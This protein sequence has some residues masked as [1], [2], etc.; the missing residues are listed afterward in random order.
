MSH[1]SRM[2]RLRIILTGVMLTVYLLVL[3][4]Q[5]HAQTAKSRA[6]M[7]NEQTA[8][9]PY[10]DT[11][12]TPE[13]KHRLDALVK[14]TKAQGNIRGARVVGF[15]DRVGSPTTTEKISRKRAESV[16]N[17][18]VSKGISNASVADMRW[19]GDS[20]PAANCPENLQ[21]PALIAC[22][23]QDRRV[24]IEIDYAVQLARAQ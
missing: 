17:Y 20:F 16:K 14:D 22:L 24:E 7:Q 11:T 23:G 3:A 10:N 15:A 1:L 5:A 13:A 6:V 21:K 18:L 12:L 4:V 19:F 9:V 8:Y 2:T